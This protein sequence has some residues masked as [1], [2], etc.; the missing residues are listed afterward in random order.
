M[1]LLSTYYLFSFLNGLYIQV[2]MTKNY[3]S[4]IERT[5]EKERE[6]EVCMYIELEIIY[7]YLL[8]K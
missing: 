7:A 4:N 2:I 1:G 5:R 8:E 6:S 3:K